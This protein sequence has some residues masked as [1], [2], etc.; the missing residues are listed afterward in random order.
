MRLNGEVALITGAAA[1]VEGELMGLGGAA[2]RLLAREGARVVVTDIQKEL[3]RR[4]ARQICDGGGDAF[5]HR[6]DMTSETQ[7]DEAVSAAVAKYGRLDVQLNSAGT[8][9]AK[10]VETMTIEPWDF[11]AD[12]H[13]KGVMLGTRRVI[14]EMRKAGRGSIINV[15]SILGLVASWHGGAYQAARAA[16][17]NFTK[18]TAIQHAKDPIRAN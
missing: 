14:P 5:F 1:G 12:L 4:T 8:R 10:N 6:L 7:W 15:S 17:R 16:V 2:A 13:A 9:G 11:M 18:S 3:G